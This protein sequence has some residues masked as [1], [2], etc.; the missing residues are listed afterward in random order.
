MVPDPNKP[1]KAKDNMIQDITQR[2]PSE[3]TNI[4]EVRDEID[5]IDHTLIKLLSQRFEYVKEVVKYKENTP[6]SIQ[7]PKR[8]MEV[9]KCR[10]QWAEENGL[11]PDVIEEMYTRLIQYF[12]DEEMKIKNL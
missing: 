10:R 6:D 11:D 4:T 5:R 9:I 1:S 2:K 3:C 12:I 7:A 8:K